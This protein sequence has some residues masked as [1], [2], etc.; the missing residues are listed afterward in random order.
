MSPLVKLKVGVWESGATRH[1]DGGGVGAGARE[2][3]RD[4]GN[5]EIEA[6]GPAASGMPGELFQWIEAWGD[7]CGARCFFV[8]RKNEA[9]RS[10]GSK[11]VEPW[12]GVREE[13]RTTLYVLCEA[14][15]FS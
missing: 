6:T 2:G 15:G 10:G 1:A 11:P 14:V 7:V 8:N 3:W 13:W 4:F 5:R 12:G 9:R